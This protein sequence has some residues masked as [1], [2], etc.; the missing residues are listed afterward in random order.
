MLRELLNVAFSYLA[1]GLD[2]EGRQ[3]LEQRLAERQPAGEEGSRNV[4]ALM[5]AFSMAGAR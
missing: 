4:E 2:H 1:E 3:Q 5:R